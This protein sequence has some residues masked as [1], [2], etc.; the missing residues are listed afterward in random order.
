MSLALDFL[1]GRWGGKDDCRLLPYSPCEDP[2]RPLLFQQLVEIA[3]NF[4]QSI[5]RTTEVG[6]V[7]AASGGCRA[8]FA[9]INR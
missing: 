5:A 9:N 2:A 7:A 4:W 8:G 3:A 1:A 6:S